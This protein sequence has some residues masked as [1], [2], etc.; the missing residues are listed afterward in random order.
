MRH[1]VFGLALAG[2]A[3]PQATSFTDGGNDTLATPGM[4]YRWSFDDG[5]VPREFFNVLGDWSVDGGELVQTGS[6][7]DPDFPR[8]VIEDLSAIDFHLTV[9]CKPERGSTDR[10]CGLLFRAVDSDNY[11]L[12]R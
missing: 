11:M 8:M 6:F 4:T 3:S 5:A 7:G 10:A 12:A 9:K 2:C 1:L